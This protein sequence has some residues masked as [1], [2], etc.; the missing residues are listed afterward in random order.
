MKPMSVQSIAEFCGGRLAG[1]DGARVCKRTSTDSRQ[2]EADDL[3]VALVGEKF[4]AHEF[5]P[6]VARKLQQRS[7]TTSKCARSS[8]SVPYSSVTRN[9]FNA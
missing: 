1:G 2:I 7:T 5:V 8:R 6:Q 9:W 3:F 4:D